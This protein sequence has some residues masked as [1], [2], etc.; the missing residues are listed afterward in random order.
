M[1]YYGA[2][3]AE[4]LEPGPFRIRTDENGFIKTGNEINGFYDVM[5]LGDSVVENYYIH[6]Q[7]RICAVAER[8]LRDA[9]L[10][11]NVYNGG[12]SGSTTLSL[13]NILISKVIP[14]KPHIV[15]LVT[16]ITDAAMCGY[17]DNFW[18]PGQSSSPLPI[19]ANV[20]QRPTSVEGLD[21]SARA[22]LIALFGEVCRQFGIRFI[23]ATYPY[24]SNLNDPLVAR[25]YPTEQSFLDET[26]AFRL[27]NEQTR[28]LASAMDIPLLDI[29]ALHPECPDLLYDIIHPNKAGCLTFGIDYAKFLS[30]HLLEIRA[31]S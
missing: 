14:L 3:C 21:L 6:E 5:V 29:Q 20:Q 23:L 10:P 4:S 24:T 11:T 30:A 16:G 1:A 15:V 13:L 8:V 27:A 2:L 12:N 19:A 25:R 31:A 18:T 28:E 22:K 17:P 26:G 7:D 9:G